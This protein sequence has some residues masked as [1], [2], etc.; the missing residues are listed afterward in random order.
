MKRPA[1]FALLA[2]LALAAAPLSAQH[3]HHKAGG[4]DAIRPLYE[5]LKTL[6]IK[7]AEAMPEADYGFKPTEK[8]RTYGQLLGH[9]ANENFIF[10]ANVL[11]QENPNKADL[12]KAGKAALVQ[13][14]TASF[15]YCD[16]AYRIDESRA[17]SETSL[18]GEKGSRLWALI[19]NVTHDS[20]HY[21]NVVTYLR[22]KG[23]T[24]PSSQGGS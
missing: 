5:R 3:E 15:T 1:P 19:Y 21:G 9:V 12:E 13:G 8:V 11:G 16:A 22:L 17:M 4:M 18:Y 2:V 14:L 7:S 20:E 6:F 23:I 24:P 10:C